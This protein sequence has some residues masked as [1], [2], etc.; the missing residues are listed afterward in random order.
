[1]YSGYLAF[2]G[3]NFD[4]TPELELI[5]TSRAMAYIDF[6][7]NLA[8][9]GI[10]GF[11]GPCIT[12][13]DECEECPSV[14]RFLAR[15]DLPW[16]QRP[17][18][19]WVDH[20]P[21][22]PWFDPFNTDSSRFLGIVGLDVQ[23]VEDAIRDASVRQS[24]GGGGYVGK[25]IQRPR[26]LVIR[27]VLVAVDEPGLNWGLEWLRETTRGLNDP[28][29]QGDN[30]WFLDACPPCAED[31]Y[32]PNCQLPDPSVPDNEACL[33]PY[34]RHFTGVRVIRGPL[35]VDYRHMPS[36]GWMA[37]I[38]MIAG[39]AGSRPSTASRLAIRR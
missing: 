8:G 30:L 20:S 35:V 27:A 37:E 12:W 24:T 2:G 9:Q 39:G 36:G 16:G 29:C 13:V 28:A 22:A 4:S 38:E 19:C 6:W 23:G 10:P 5:N 25:V 18:Y 7:N 31:S 21:P 32:V 17:G 3:T 33:R 34:V 11:E 15:R 26:E 1:M 14:D